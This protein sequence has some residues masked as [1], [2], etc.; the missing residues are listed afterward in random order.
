MYRVWGRIRSSLISDWAAAKAPFWDRVVAG[1]SA[2]RAALLGETSMEIAST[3]QFTWATVLYDGEKF[4]A[5]VSFEF[6]VETA[7]RMEVDYPLSILALALQMH[8]APRHVAT[9][10][11]VSEL[12]WPQQSLIAGC[13]QSVDLGRLALRPARHVPAE[14]AV[15]VGRRPGAS[16]AGTAAGSGQ[17][18]PGGGPGFGRHAGEERL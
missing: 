15:D 16:G 8:S 1:S 17:Q 10:E 3:L 12:Q 6:I 14:G 5:S 11:A 7:M 2:L 4:Y 9:E 13:S 18:G